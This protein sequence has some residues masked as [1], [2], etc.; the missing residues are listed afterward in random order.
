LCTG[1]GNGDFANIT[2]ILVSCGIMHGVPQ[3]QD[4]GS[5][6]IFDTG[7]EWS[8]KLYTCASAV[9]ATIKSVSFNYNG[10]EGLL[11]SLAITDI[12]DKVYTDES[13]MPL[14][15][16]E[17]T[18]NRYYMSDLNLIW[19]LV[20]PTYENDI[21]VSTVRQPSLYL[22]GWINPDSPDIGGEAIEDFENLPGSDFS[23]GA[24]Q[25]AYC[26]SSTSS[27]GSTDYSGE[28]NM[29]M[30]ARWQNLTQSAETASLIPNLIFTD[31]AASAIVGTR[32]VL[33]PGNT[34]QQNLV[35]IQVMPTV[36]KVRYNFLFAI[37]AL[38]VA[39]ML[40]PITLIA[41][42]T[43][44]FSGAGIARIRLHLQ[45]VS[46]G[47][48]YTTFLYPG[49]GSLTMKSKDWAIHWGNKVIDLSG[50]YPVAADM[51]PPHENG[52]TV[53]EQEQQASDVSPSG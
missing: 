40:V 49:P 25:T 23:V 12:Q 17:N 47:R 52:A 2:N 50:E 3:R 1:A 20:S 22:P 43:M 39:L 7:S 14:W 18:D 38:L 21:N 16:V 11:S 41:I 31:I 44:C 6:L 37:P 29:A 42:V 15:G 24:L 35:A 45:Q 5:N 9:K 4:P 51:M 48:I 26:V 30:W 33:G 53:M 10:T 34:A 19:G 13:S 32:G 27:C 36:S 28:T 8:Q 46:P